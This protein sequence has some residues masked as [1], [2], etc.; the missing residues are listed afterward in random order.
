MAR[1]RR[2]GGIARTWLITGGVLGCPRRRVAEQG[3]DSGQRAL[4][5]ALPLPRWSSRCRRNAP[6]R[7]AYRSA[8]LT[9]LGAF[10]VLACAKAKAS[11]SL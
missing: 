8:R 3:L 9:V 11:R 4:R 6:I 7:A 10:P 2:R 5:V 1:S